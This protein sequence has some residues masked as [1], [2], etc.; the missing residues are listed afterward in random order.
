MR[1][2][3]S[4][5]GGGEVETRWLLWLRF[6]KK[7]RPKD[8]CNEIEFFY[9]IWKSKKNNDIKYNNQLKLGAT[10]CYY[11]IWSCGKTQSSENLP[12]LKIDVIVN[13]K[14]WQRFKNIVYKGFCLCYS[15]SDLFTGNKPLK[16]SN[17]NY[18]KKTRTQL[19]LRTI[20]R[21]K[22][23]DDKAKDGEQLRFY[24]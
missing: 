16:D 15:K 20:A 24:R 14:P 9:C 13:T 5:G 3:L 23:I 19:L 7:K 18:K 12:H 2:T 10:G 8:N 6:W 4:G 1:K 21:H 11:V 22:L 17:R